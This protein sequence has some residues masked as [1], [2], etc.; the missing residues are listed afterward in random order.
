MS[1]KHKS[2]THITCTFPYTAIVNEGCVLNGTSYIIIVAAAI[3]NVYCVNKG[4]DFAYC[5]AGTSD[6]ELYDDGG[7]MQRRSELAEVFCA[8]PH[9]PVPVCP[10][11]YCV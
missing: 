5:G 7:P 8:G 6:L 3:K 2:K 11:N 9:P 1:K 4:K 10:L